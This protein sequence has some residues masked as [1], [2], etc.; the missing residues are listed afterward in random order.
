MKLADKTVGM[1]LGMGFSLVLVLL[2][3]VTVLGI[4]RMAQIQEHLEKV[5]NVNNVGTRLVTD[6]SNVVKDRIVALR[7][8][9]LLTEASD[10]EPEIKRIEAQ[11]AVYASAQQQLSA[12]FATEASISTQEKALLAA[13]KEHEAA[14]MPLIANAT[15]LWLADKPEDATILLIRK[16]RP[17]QKKWMDALDEL[18][19]LEDKQSANAVAAARASFASA[20]TLMISLG[21]LA[22]LVG[23]AAALV[24]TRGLLR[25][26]GGEPAYAAKIAAQI[27]GGDLSAEIKTAS[28]NPGSL[29]AEMKTMRDSLVGIVGQVRNGTDTIAS[30]SSEIA[31]GNLD[32]SS[33]TAHQAGS[34]ERTASS[35]EELTGTV[36]QN[37][38]NARHANQLAASASE[39]ARKGG[40]VVSEV[41]HTMGAI[42]AS[43]KKIVDII[44]V[45]DGIAFQTNILA[46]N[47]AVEAARAGE[48]G[49]G[50]AVVATEVRNLAQRSASAAKEI[51]ALIG[52]SVEKV[53]SG[54]KLV[55]Q[56]G[57]TMEE[58]VQSVKRVT[59]IISEI[60][61]A[62]D[63][64]SAG[65]GQVNAAIADMEGVTQQNAALVEQAASAAQSLQSQAAELARVVSVF[66]LSASEQTQAAYISSA[67]PS[68][69]LPVTPR[70]VPAARS[71]PVAALPKTR[72][73]K[74][75]AIGSSRSNSARH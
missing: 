20:R 36:K 34:L 65:I 7:N 57:A 13:I 17:V 66:K 26:L 56:A 9:S 63:E 12:L 50:F 23:I 32:L 31:A 74:L 59:D 24:I 47:A 62:S 48:Q 39:V 28:N 4:S 73:K 67:A 8:L 71:A 30:A 51:K 16:I 6:M 22:V 55:D 42:D 45:I 49:R 64:Q 38:D 14:A 3:A 15:A 29:L 60:T 40:A 11:N 70:A 5:V 75:A 46:L 41:V 19:A 61:A 53:G 2:V 27:A 58:V 37:A 44:G 69:P 68:A 43:A 10:M 1:R 52:D 33:R 72:T 18:A 35:M 54:T 25:Q 21:L